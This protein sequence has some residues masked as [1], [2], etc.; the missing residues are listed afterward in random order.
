[1]S[2]N[3]ASRQRLL[4]RFWLGE[5]PGGTGGLSDTHAEG[6]IEIIEGTMR[7]AGELRGPPLRVPG[8]REQD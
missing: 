5:D 3:S 4:Q 2:T 7:L 6:V 1:M 8:T